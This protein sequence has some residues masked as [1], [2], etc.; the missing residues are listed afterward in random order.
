MQKKIDLSYTVMPIKNVT[1][2]FLRA[3]FFQGPKA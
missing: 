1:L 2:A 3:K